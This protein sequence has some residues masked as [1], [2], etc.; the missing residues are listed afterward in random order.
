MFFHLSSTL[1][2]FIGLHGVDERA[3]VAHAQRL[4][5]L[6]S[7]VSADCFA[8]IE[9]LTQTR[10]VKQYTSACRCLAAVKRRGFEKEF[11]L[12]RKSMNVK[13]EVHRLYIY[14]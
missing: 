7:Q 13:C 9:N 2:R 11:Q 1:H 10:T 12:M 6:Y 5:K 4:L 8:I 14:Q 3:S